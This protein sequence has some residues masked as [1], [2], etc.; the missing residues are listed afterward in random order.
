[1]A[2]GSLLDRAGI[3]NGDL[4]AEVN[5]MQASAADAFFRIRE[6]LRREQHL[7]GL[8]E[9]SGRKMTLIYEITS[10]LPTATRWGLA[11]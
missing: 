4:I 1:M 8:L 10:T 3:R 7:R 2:C 5:E 6:L 9:R 11:D